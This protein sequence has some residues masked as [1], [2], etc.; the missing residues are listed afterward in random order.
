MIT[1]IDSSVLWAIIKQ[2]AGWEAWENALLHAA[3]EGPLIICP[4]NKSWSPISLLATP[5]A[6]L[7]K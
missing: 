3:T 4:R 1:A 6:D 2:E 5:A 7:P